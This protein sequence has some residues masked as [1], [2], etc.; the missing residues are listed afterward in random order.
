MH[1]AIVVLRPGELPVNGD[2]VRY[3]KAATALERAGRGGAALTALKAAT[4]HWPQ[5]ASTHFALANAY[6]AIGDSL[7]AERSYRLA[8]T[9]EPGDF[10][11]MN[12][13]ARLL[14]EQNRCDE[15]RETIRP[16]IIAPD[17]NPGL[18]DAVVSTNEAIQRRCAFD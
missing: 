5:S 8:L 13:L 12:N 14:L 11:A 7:R 1:W 4:E 3:L 15:A 17:A 18:Q 9:V 16:A 2:R 10:A 6:H